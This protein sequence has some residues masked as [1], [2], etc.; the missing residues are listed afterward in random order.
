MFKAGQCSS[1]A[2]VL[3]ALVLLGS[4]VVHGAEATK[5][6][7]VPSPRSGTASQAPAAGSTAPATPQKT[8]VDDSYQIGPED[9]IDIAVWN[10]TAISRTVPVRPDGKI[11]LPLLNDVQAAGL[12]PMGLRDSIARK[13][14]EYMPTPEVSVIVREIH[15]FKVTVMGSVKKPGRYEMR[16]QAT[17]LDAVAQAGGLDEFASP[18][19]LTILRSNG[20]TVQ[21]IVVRYKKALTGEVDLARLLVKPGDTVV[22]P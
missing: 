6:R 20:G 3:T 4:C 13:L 12:T 16:S 11:S 19:R 10:N 5:T 21:K 22:V 1:S 17:V 14:E 9:V 7:P 18:S 8:Q 15:S 2:A